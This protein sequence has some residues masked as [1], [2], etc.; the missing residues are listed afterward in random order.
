MTTEVDINTD[1]IISESMKHQ[2]ERNSIFFIEQTPSTQ[3]Q[4]D[5]RLIPQM[6]T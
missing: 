6:C 5:I 1:R 4:Q 3:S 2:K